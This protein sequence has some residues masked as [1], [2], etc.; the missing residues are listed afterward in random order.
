MIKYLVIIVIL[1]TGCSATEP[2]AKRNSYRE[3]TFVFNCE[4][5]FQF[6]ARSEEPYTLWAF[7]PG[8]TLQL[9]AVVSA[10]G[11]KYQNGSNWV[12][13]KGENALVE[14]N[15][16]RYRNCINNRQEAIWQAAKLSGVSFRAKGNEPAWVIEIIDGEHIHYIGDYGN[17]KLAFP[18]YAPQ[19][20]ETSSVFE[21]TK[22]GDHL[23]LT[24][25][26]EQCV[27]SM[28]GQEFAVSVELV[29]NDKAHQGCGRAL[30]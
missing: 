22:G 14:F 23:V 16:K 4:S 1:L 20:R 27:D 7:F 19:Q 26:N 29:I 11:V 5:E 17:T 21:T 25:T 13:L 18:F 28:S 9:Q 24:L 15:Q 6:V 30:Y 10:S 3:K 12:W 8:Q 2:T